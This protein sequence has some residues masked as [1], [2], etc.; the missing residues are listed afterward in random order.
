MKKIYLSTI[1]L[2]LI[3]GIVSTANSQSL[4]PVSDELVLPQYLVNGSTSGARL[5]YICHLK[6]S[7]LTP[8][9]TYKYTTGASNSATLTTGTAPGNMF[10]I[11]NIANAYGNVV[12]YTTSKG[13]GATAT[14]LDGDV[15]SS[16]ANYLLFTTDASGTYTGW[17]SVVP[18]GNAAFTVG[19]TVYFYI[20]LNDGA[21]GTSITQSFRTTS[22][23]TVLGAGVTNSS[24]IRG[25]SLATKESF[26]LLYDNTSGNGRPVYGTWSENDGITTTFSSWYNPSSGTA[27]DGVAG[28]WGAYIPSNLPDGIRRIE[29]HDI[30]NAFIASNTDEDGIWPSG[31]N[32]V[33]PAASTTPIIISNTDAPLQPVVVDVTAPTFTVNIG[34]GDI[35]VAVNTSIVLTFNE[36]IRNIDDSE[37]TDANLA[38]LLTLKETDAAGADVPF[39]ATIDADKKVI[40]VTP[41]SD[42]KNGQVYYAVIAPVEDAANNATEAA[43]MTFTTIAATAS[44]ISDVAI[45]ETAPYF[46]GSPVTITWTSTNVTDV[47]IEAWI[48]SESKWETLFA[49]IP[50]DGSEAFTI[51]ADAQYSTEYKIRVTNVA[52][53]AVTGESSAFTIIAV[54]NNLL[55]LR[56][57][58]VNSIVKYTGIATVTFAQTTRN[59]KYIQDAT[60]AV[61]I[62]DPNPG[63]IGAYEIGEG[64]TN[65]V[66]KILLYNQLIEFTPQAATGEHV[67]GSVIVPEVRTLESLT[68]ADQCKL[69][70]IENFAFKTPTQYDPTGVFVK[71]K[72]YDLEGYDN[73]LLAFRTAFTAADYIG[74]MVPVGTISAVCLVGQFNAQMQI[75]A[76]SWSDFILPFELPKLVIT[77]IMYNSPEST[78]EEWFELY[79]NGT[80]EVDMS[81][82]YMVDSDI[83]HIAN[84]WVFPSGSVIGP[85]E[86]FTAKLSSGGAFPFLPDAAL[87]T[88]GDPFNLGNSSDQVKIYHSNGQLI[89]S[90]QYFDTWYPETDG[91]GASLTLCDPS[92]DNSLAENWSASLDA[93]TTLQ[94]NTIYAT[95]GS[96]C[97]L[98]AAVSQKV[99]SG[100]FVYPNPTSDKLYISNPANE[101]LEISILSSL[102]KTVKTLL[103]NQGT[104]SVDLSDLPKGIYMVKSFN[105]SNRT[106]QVNKV[107]VR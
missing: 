92:A 95:P 1:L 48:P 6:I 41:T 74:G 15:I 2:F 82:F 56:T 19:N 66:G 59:Q 43:S 26:I 93:F 5:Q 68:T 64:I 32:T 33:N 31:A 85:G 52:N 69:V 104:T 57:Q 88:A 34:N 14:L 76:R 54:V 105:K 72:N 50:S 51:P 60:A 9:A 45:T 24:A 61:L 103:S 25:E 80:T 27:V 102:G 20:Q 79:N 94:G 21:G 40:T 98:H 3:L 97:I 55:A 47:M 107:I 30:S 37:I 46:A 65:I 83:A 23:I 10:G 8:N 106:S 62:D 87:T 38:A 99:Q 100:I 22:T 81:G 49:S 35:N 101:S 53:A 36:A 44:A 11:N 7:G 89:D 63:F 86:Y 28:S 84:P 58:P 90:V 77:E 70:K 18:T 4:I 42:L 29:A 39:T 16:T 75:T 78:D 17:F 67:T 96:G 12:G 13:V 91:T 73:T 71:S